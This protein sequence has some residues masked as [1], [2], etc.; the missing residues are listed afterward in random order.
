M[1]PEIR[2]WLD[3]V[4]PAPDGWRWAKTLEAARALLETGSV[5]EASLDHDLGTDERGDE[6]PAGRKLVLWM[7]EHGVWPRDGVSIHSANVVGVQHMAALIERYGPYRALP[8]R[9]RFVPREPA[10]GD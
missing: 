2:L 6:L 8:G 3:D 7:C 4:R 1:T 9:R 10:Q 5:V